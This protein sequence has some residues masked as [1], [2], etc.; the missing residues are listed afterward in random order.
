MQQDANKMIKQ[1]DNEALQTATGGCTGCGFVASTALEKSGKTL[2]KLQ[3][4]LRE[5]G[6]S[7]V[8]ARHS[9]K[10]TK[11]RDLAQR[12]T[13]SIPTPSKPGCSHCKN[14]KGFAKELVPQL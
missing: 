6:S 1:L 9:E 7:E 12:A 8:I 13:N 3:K 11:L 5:G 4:A 14:F 10:S 2:N